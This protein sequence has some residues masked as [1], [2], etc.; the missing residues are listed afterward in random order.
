VRDEDRQIKALLAWFTLLLVTGLGH[1]AVLQVRFADEPVVTTAMSEAILRQTA[2]VEAIDT[3]LVVAALLTM[4]SPAVFGNSVAPSRSYM[5]ASWAA[6]APALVALLAVNVGYHWLLGQWLRLPALEPEMRETRSW[7]TFVTVCVQP[8]IV[9]E[10]FCRRLAMSSLRRVLGVHAAVL[11]AAA[12][13]SLLHIAV[14]LSMPY[15]FLVG[16]VL[17]YLRVVG[18]TL[19]LPVVVHFLHN[20][21]ILAYEWN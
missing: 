14:L 21:A 16:V 3:L 4:R 7:L 9:E 19:W 10:V 15:L 1:A 2:T 18:G 8:A 13:F 17:G 6:A 20:F 12:M 5:A 11:I